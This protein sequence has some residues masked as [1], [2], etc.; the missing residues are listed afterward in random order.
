MT[1]N[2]AYGWALMAFSTHKTY[3][4]SFKEGNRVSGFP[5]LR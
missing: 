3:H 4:C 2:Q 1:K 5:V